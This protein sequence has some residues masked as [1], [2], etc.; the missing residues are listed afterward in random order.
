MS[1]L[2]GAAETLAPNGTVKTLMKLVCSAA[3]IL[4]LLTELTGFDTGSYALELAKYRTLER[5]LTASAETTRES[6]SRL[7]IED[8]C[9]AYIKDKARERGA[10]V[11]ELAVTL[12]WSRE[13]L[14]VPVSLCGTADSESSAETAR[15]L[16]RTELGIPEERQ[17]W[18]I[19]GG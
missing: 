7:V 17:E 14:W 9:E 10:T 16:A 4:S 6:M 18:S 2:C 8:E 13:G 3:V 12:V 1:I 15:E 5:E 11:T 19:G